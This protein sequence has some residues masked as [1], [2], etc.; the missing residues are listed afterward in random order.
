MDENFQEQI[1][2]LKKFAEM[3]KSQ[4][5][6]LYESIG[7]IEKSNLQV[8]NKKL[9]DERTKSTQYIS[10][11]EHKLK[12]TSIENK[13]MKTALYEQLFSEKT[14]ILKQSK[15]VIDAYFA[16]G[17]TD[18]PL[19]K[20][21]E[22]AKNR[23]NNIKKMW[24]QEVG[25]EE[26]AFNQQVT[27]LEKILQNKI[28]ECRQ[29]RSE[30]LA[31]ERDS[32]NEAYKEFEKKPLTTEQVQ[33]RIKHNSMELHL[34]SKI[35][36]VI[37][38]VLVLLG[39]VFGVQY[40]YTSLLQSNELKATFAFLI[41]V[42]F[43]A[44]GEWRNRKELNYFST[45]LSAGGIGILF[46]ATAIAYFNLQV[47]SMYPTILLC[48]LIALLAFFL[49]LRY[50]S[51]VIGCFALIG[52]YLPI[53]SI[54]YNLPV[55]YTALAYFLILNFL[56]ILIAIRQKW[57]VQKYI[58]F[59]FNSLGMVYIIVLLPLFNKAMPS[60]I[61]IPYVFI[62][63]AMYLVLILISPYK[64]KSK[65]MPSDVVL[66]CLDTLL[67]CMMVY[68]LVHIN[69]IYEINGLFAIVFCC[70][71]YAVAKLVATKIENRRLSDFFYLASLAF[72]ILVIPLQLGIFYL[73]LGWIVEAVL[74]ICFG[75][76]KNYRRYEYAG[77]AIF[78]M[79]L[80]AFFALDIGDIGAVDFLLRYTAMTIA[81]IAILSVYIYKMQ[82][83]ALYFDANK[84][85]GIKIFTNVVAINGWL[86][87]IYLAYFVY[88][89][90][91]YAQDTPNMAWFIAIA[92]C[93]TICYAYALG[94]IK[95]LKNR[96]Y[97]VIPLVLYA[98]AI[99]G[100]L[101]VNS[102]Q[103]IFPVGHQTIGDLYALAVILLVVVNL[104]SVLALRETILYF[105]R[106]GEASSEV[107]P[108]G[109]SVFLLIVT[110]Q[111]FVV[112]FSI[113]STNMCLSFIIMIA[114]LINIVFGFK[115]LYPLMRRFGL[116]L[117]LAS[118]TKL[119]IL[120]LFFLN[121]GQ[122]IVSYFVFGLVLIGISYVYQLF[123][124]KLEFK[125]KGDDESV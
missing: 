39:V 84:Q 47:L 78:V 96:L 124:K 105:I 81:S 45:G 6:I 51:Q 44:A 37:G 16:E 95:Y 116:L 97:S 54:T 77:L 40:T 109:I 91:A 19:A 69:H 60:Y 11:L 30:A 90:V 21:E 66:I 68:L 13:N 61:S 25:H 8:E 104:I 32:V 9:L 62:S 121:A 4:I 52:G 86:F 106:E 123:A 120:D 85:N 23:I 94:K 122:R 17:S 56:A 72:A 24:R 12:T 110:M 7:T 87:L 117:A 74:F 119:F 89:K 92:A 102:V 53:F 15:K 113:Q 70:L 38:L 42:L 107:Y 93:I 48:I 111:V 2:N 36:N 88:E 29:K 118:T 99:V 100:C 34:G 98:L 103:F 22:T 14:H 83:D 65:L 125:I 108:L 46:A 79:C 59:I 3:Q 82:K 73:S 1:G 80:V 114:A 55:Q 43:L 33:N 57:I 75:V 18:K 76:L 49:S 64:Q 67:S 27:E 31:K 35:I 112:Q 26:T 5:N 71:Y 20:F 41:G 10:E 58:S 28:A 101:Y 63:F 115:K 50:R